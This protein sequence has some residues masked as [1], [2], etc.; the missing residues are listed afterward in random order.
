MIVLAEK[1]SKIVPRLLRYSCWL[2][3]LLGAMDSFAAVGIDMV[4][5]EPPANVSDEVDAEVWPET[6]LTLALLR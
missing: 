3:V 5:V 1:V 2:W 6:A 4:F